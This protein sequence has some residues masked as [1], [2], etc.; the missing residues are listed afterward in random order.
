MVSLPLLGRC[1]AGLAEAIHVQLAQ[2]DDEA[3]RTRVRHLSQ[4]LSMLGQLIAE[5]DGSAPAPDTVAIPPAVLLR[6]ARY[7]DNAADQVSA[8]GLLPAEFDPQHADQL[9]ATFHRDAIRL[10]TIAQSATAD[11]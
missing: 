8:E 2:N 9:A 7:L 1:I 6:V 11:S 10:R 5:A 3:V 4:T